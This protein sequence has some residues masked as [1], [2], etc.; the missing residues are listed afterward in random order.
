VASTGLLGVASSLVGVQL[1]VTIDESAGTLNIDFT[2]VA[3]AEFSLSGSRVTSRWPS[4]RRAGTIDG[5]GNIVLPNM[6]VA[7][8]TE[9]TPKRSAHRPRSRP[10][11][12][13]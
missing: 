9:V 1:P 11:S 12:R 6:L 8:T 13:P 10:G 5:A 4:G 3:P 7:F 2:G